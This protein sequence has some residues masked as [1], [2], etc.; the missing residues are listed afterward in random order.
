MSILSDF[1]RQEVPKSGGAM[2]AYY[3]RALFISEAILAVYF[4]AGAILSIRA[5]GAWL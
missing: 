4:L 5:A 2:P 1:F 3:R